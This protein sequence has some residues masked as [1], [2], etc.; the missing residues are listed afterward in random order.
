[1]KV[2][3]RKAVQGDDGFSLAELQGLLTEHSV[4]IFSR[5]VL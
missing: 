1:M 3:W 2:L 5:W 4:C